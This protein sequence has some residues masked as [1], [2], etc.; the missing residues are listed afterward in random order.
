VTTDWIAERHLEAEF[1]N[2]ETRDVIVRIARPRMR[3]DEFHFWYALFEIEG[4]TDEP[5]RMDAFGPGDSLDALQF[6][7]VHAGL[8]LQAYEERGIRL[9]WLGK[10]SLGFPR[11]KSFDK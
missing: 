9:T 8:R 1:P 6:A 10:P 4:I 11:P 3:D 2:G 7:M 5:Y